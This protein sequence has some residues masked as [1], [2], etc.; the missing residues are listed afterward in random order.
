MA[1]E[2]YAVLTPPTGSTFIAGHA[3][4]ASQAERIRQN[5]VQLGKPRYIDLGGSEIDG[6]G[7]ECV[8]YA[9]LR[10]GKVI[11]LCEE[12]FR[13]LTL[14][15]QVWAKLLAGTST[16]QVRL[17]NIDDNADV[18]EMASAVTVTSL[19]MYE[20][21]CVL[22]A[23]TTPKQCRLEIECPGGDADPGVA[24]GQIKL[25]L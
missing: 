18:A 9:R 22:P 7:D 2:T 16:V 5:L 11:E 24:F 4:R 25:E 17:R 15:L 20:V 21:T 8:T 1:G 12:H 13:G 10:S 6:H 19:T 23:G 3:V 14:T